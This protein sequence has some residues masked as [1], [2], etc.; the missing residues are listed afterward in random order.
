MRPPLRANAASLICDANATS[1]KAPY[2]PLP[3]AF[4]TAPS[5]SS[6]CKK[7]A[8]PVP[9]AQ[10]RQ[11]GLLA[12]REEAQRNLGSHWPQLREVDTHGVTAA[13]GKRREI[14]L[15]L[16]IAEPYRLRRYGQIPAKFWRQTGNDELDSMVPGALCLRV[17][18]RI[19]IGSKPPDLDVYSVRGALDS[20]VSRRGAR[21]DI[22]VHDESAVSARASFFGR[23]RC[24]WQPSRLRRR[25]DAQSRRTALWR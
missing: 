9:P 3:L 11:D 7:G 15:W 8:E 25:C 2:Q 4:S 20:H 12:V 23:S 19:G 10:P 14:A 1:N 18:R 13:R 6:S 21:L 16:R 22:Q 17:C 24:A 5:A